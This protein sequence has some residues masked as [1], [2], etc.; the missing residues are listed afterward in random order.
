MAPRK[1]D[2]GQLQLIEVDSPETKA[3]KRHALQYMRL[4]ESNASERESMRDKES[5]KA[6]KL[7]AALA[8]CGIKPGADGRCEC[9]IGGMHIIIPAM[10]NPAVRVKMIEDRGE[11]E[12]EGDGEE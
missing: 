5:D 4:R 10:R 6:D 9:E 12:E 3:A 1:A 2:E 7:R 8:A 11:E